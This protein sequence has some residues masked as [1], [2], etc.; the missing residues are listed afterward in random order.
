MTVLKADRFL[1]RI[2]RK[3]Q[4]LAETPRMGR[5]REELALSLRSFPLGNYAVFYR[6]TEQGIEVIRILHGARDIE[7]VFEVD[8]DA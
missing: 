3:L 5:R 4:A 7:A 6:P 2:E 8:D 1:E